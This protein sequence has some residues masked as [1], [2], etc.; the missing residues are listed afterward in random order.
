MNNSA[1]LLLK[2]L[3]KRAKN[4][5]VLIQNPCSMVEFVRLY[6]YLGIHIERLIPLIGFIEGPR[7]AK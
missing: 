5:R 4:V 1:L 6:S 7:A 2:I 3:K